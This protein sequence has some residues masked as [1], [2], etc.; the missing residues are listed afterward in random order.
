MFKKNKGFYLGRYIIFFGRFKDIYLQIIF[1]INFIKFE[2]EI[3]FIKKLKK[4]ETNAKLFFT[5][6]K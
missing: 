1:P 4:K 2:F 5:V 6:L 3:V